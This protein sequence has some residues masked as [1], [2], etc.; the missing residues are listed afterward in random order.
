MLKEVE[1]LEQEAQER[2]DLRSRAKTD[3]NARNELR[4]LEW[5]E[6]NEIY[7]RAAVEKHNE[8]R[9][10]HK[11]TNDVFFSSELAKDAQAWAD[12]FTI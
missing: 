7:N 6:E 5:L 3:S 4:K 8:L 10:M 2:A 9:R 12:L 1:R 11:K